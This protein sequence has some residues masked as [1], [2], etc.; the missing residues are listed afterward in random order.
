VILGVSFDTQEENAAFHEKFG[1]TFPLLCDRD[2]TMGLAYGAAS[3]PGTGGYAGRVG[4]VI[5]PSGKIIFY[6]LK[7]DAKLFPRQAL[8]M[9]A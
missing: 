7:V 2:R 5:D 9:M 4:V 8:D 3:Q 1:F 6:D